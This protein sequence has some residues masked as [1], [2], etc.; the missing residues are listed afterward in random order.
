MRFDKGILIGIAIR[1]GNPLNIHLAEMIWKLLAGIPLC[2]RD[3]TE[4]DKVLLLFYSSTFLTFLFQHFLP[5]ILYIK[6]IDANEL[7]NMKLPFSVYS[8]SGKVCLSSCQHFSL[9]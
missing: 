8:A 5:K 1:S 9:H 2:L 7:E 3:I 4:I 6:E